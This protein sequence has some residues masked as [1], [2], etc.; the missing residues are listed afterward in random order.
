MSPNEI[1][2][3]MPL[4]LR[5]IHYLGGGLSTNAPTPTKH[6]KWNEGGY[7]VKSST[8]QRGHRRQNAIV[9][10]DLASIPYEGIG[11]KM[12]LYGMIWRPSYAL[13]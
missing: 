4:Q 2:A 11:V 1:L 13:K 8:R 7:V 10:D 6:D 3:E 5:N 9:W 12:Q